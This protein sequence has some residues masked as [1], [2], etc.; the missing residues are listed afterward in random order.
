VE[1]GCPPERSTGGRCE[2]SCSSAHD[3]TRGYWCWR[4]RLARNAAEA[5]TIPENPCAISKGKSQ[6]QGE[7]VVGGFGTPALHGDIGHSD[8]VLGADEVHN[9]DWWPLTTRLVWTIEDVDLV[10]PRQEAHACDTRD[11]RR[12]QNEEALLWLQGFQLDAETGGRRWR[13]GAAALWSQRGTLSRECDWRSG[14]RTRMFVF[15]QVGVRL[16]MRHVVSPC[17][18]YGMI[19]NNMS[20][21]I[22]IML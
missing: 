21:I 7:Q 13:R 12:G 10:E 14:A 9:V 17:H 11:Q 18:V 6:S 20:F 3:A 15:L 4:E 16:A 8:Q 22:N 1:S 5:L 2:C 19:H